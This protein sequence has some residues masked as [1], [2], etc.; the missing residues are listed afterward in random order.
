MEYC[1]I[2]AGS[3]G[4]ILSPSTSE[5][6]RLVLVRFAYQVRRRRRTLI[7]VPLTMLRNFAFHNPRDL[8]MSGQ[9]VG[10]SLQS[11]CLVDRGI[12]K[13]LAKGSP[14]ARPAQAPGLA[15]RLPRD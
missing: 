12:G 7:Y 6:E 4:I 10:P 13:A 9:G 15:K 2:K 5:R 14:M 11:C 3:L 8:A 1:V